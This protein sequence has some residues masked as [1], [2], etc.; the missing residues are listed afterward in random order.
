MRIRGHSA[1]SVESTLGA[2]AALAVAALVAPG[3]FETGSAAQAVVAV[4]AVEAA[5]AA[6]AVEASRAASAVEAVDTVDAAS[7]IEAVSA[8]SLVG[9][10]MPM[11]AP[12][13]SARWL[14]PVSPPRLTKGYVAP[15]TPYAAGHRG[16]DIAAEAGAAV[17]APAAGTVHFS[18]V[19]VDR[20][21][22]TID[23]GD[24]VLSSYEPV[25]SPLTV[26]AV[27]AAGDS[28]GSVASGAHCTGECIHVGVRIDGE[29]VSP[30]LF[31]DRVPPSVLLPL[32]RAS[33]AG[34]R[35]PV[36]LLEALGRD[37][38]VD[39]RRPEAR[40]AEDLLHRP[41]V[42][43]PVEQMRRRGVAQRVRPRGP[44]AGDVGQESGDQLVDGAGAEP[45][46]AGKQKCG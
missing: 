31:F 4:S 25:A 12:A 36:G 17:I 44:P 27:V 37:V 18:G 42:R 5:E 20:P 23:H 39:L 15:A 30:L 13:S 8:V 33:G 24:G 46:A 35:D 19:V 40:M 41:Q 22:L 14:W 34:M 16:I 29:Y 43:S 38:R 2:I 6:S 28:I 26:G 1:R 7:A 11:Q 21:V 32:R 10:D 3:L 45:P 9:P